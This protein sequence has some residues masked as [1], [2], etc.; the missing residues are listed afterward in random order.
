MDRMA[1]QE[2]EVNQ[3][4]RVRR[5]LQVLDSRV[6]GDLRDPL[7]FRV[8]AV[9]AARVPPVVLVTQDQQADPA[10]QDRWALLDLQVIVTPTPVWATMWEPR[11][12]PES[13]RTTVSRRRTS[14]TATTSPTTQRRGLWPPMTQH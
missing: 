5:D 14:R 4:K 13:S 8:R 10:S 1:S 6:P 9:P 12:H 11:C 2:R 3:E 7:V